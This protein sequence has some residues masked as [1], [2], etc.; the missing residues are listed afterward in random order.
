[1]STLNCTELEE[2]AALA[3]SLGVNEFRAQPLM[4]LGRTTQPS[5]EIVPSPQQYR[6]VVRTIENLRC[7]YGQAMTIEWGDPVD[8]LIRFPSLLEHCSTFLGI[9]ANGATSC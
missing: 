7:A 1:M 8:H 6:E 5:Q 4:M 9:K 3:R 2:A